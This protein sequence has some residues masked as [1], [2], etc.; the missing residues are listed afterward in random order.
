MS[1]KRKL[2][3]KLDYPMV[4]FLQINRINK[5]LS[6]ERM[7]WGMIKLLENAV[8][9][10]ESNLKPYCPGKNVKESDLEELKK[11]NKALEGLSQDVDKMDA[12]LEKL[13]EKYV[14]L[15]ILGEKAGLYARYSDAP[16]EYGD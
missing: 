10:L 5:I 14:Q 4:V 16:S 2:S 15:N 11:V 13:K 3:K 1:G 9:A 6:N 12:I 7:S 8:F